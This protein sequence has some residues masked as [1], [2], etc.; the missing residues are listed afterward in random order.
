[1]MRVLWLPLAALIGIGAYLAFPSR[2]APVDGQRV[3]YSP[4]TVLPDVKTKGPGPMAKGQSESPSAF[5]PIASAAR[6]PVAALMPSKEALRA[7]VGLDPHVTP[8]ALLKFSVDVYNKMA[9][10]KAN[11]TAAK[12]LIAELKTCALDRDGAHS[13]QALCLL[14]AKRLANQYPGFAADYHSLEGQA[15]PQVLKIMSSLPL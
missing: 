5:G 9:V 2:P 1:M 14:N 12:D 11:E 7:D 10:A 15:D 4:G 3:E 6:V 8:K 13:V